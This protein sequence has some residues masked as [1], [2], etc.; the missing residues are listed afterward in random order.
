V[1]LNSIRSDFGK[2]FDNRVC[3]R[4]I[5]EDLGINWYPAQKEPGAAIVERFNR[6]LASAMTK[7]VTAN[8]TTT[9]S[10]LLNLVQDFVDSYNN[11]VHSATRQTPQSLQDHAYERGNTS[12]I[13][14]LEDVAAGGTGAV[15]SNP[16]EEP[17]KDVRLT[18]AGTLQST[19]MGR[20]KKTNPWDPVTGPREDKPLRVGA[21]VRLLKRPDIFRKGSR[22]KA[23]TDEV[24]TVTRRSRNNPNAYYVADESG[25]ELE[26]RVYRRQLQE[27]TNVPDQWEI[28]VL[29]RRKSTKKGRRGQL[30]LLVE[31]V[32]FPGR[33]AEW[34]PASDASGQL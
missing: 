28:R 23:F 15:T 4:E 24:F 30:E 16:A 31:C 8:P 2:E 33:P 9:Q 3:R 14:I 7:Y 19:R 1:R 34:I 17:D 26:G 18:L 32:G 29:R 25:Q 20:N 11:T 10:Q 12:G 27:L 5:Y 6:T 13:D 22:Q 21:H